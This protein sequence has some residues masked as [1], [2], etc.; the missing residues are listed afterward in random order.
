[1]GNSTFLAPKRGHRE[2]S[3]FPRGAPI[4]VVVVVIVAV[5][6]VV[7][8][9]VV[10]KYYYNMATEDPLFISF[11]PSRGEE[12]E[13]PSN[14]LRLSRRE[15]L[16]GARNL[17]RGGP[18]KVEFS[19]RCQLNFIDSVIFFNVTNTCFNNIITT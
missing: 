8:V 13:I 16:Q 1:M 14:F 4:V 7:V 11:P 19:S 15:T 10:V 12:L 9:V 6:V 2:R 5:V 17:R 18:K 3:A